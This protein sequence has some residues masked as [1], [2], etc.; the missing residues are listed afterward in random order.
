MQ[1]SLVSLF[2]SV[3]RL[4][5]SALLGGTGRD[6][7]RRAGNVNTQDANEFPALS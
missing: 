6:N 5:C 4:D 1:L 3:L 2:A 7:R